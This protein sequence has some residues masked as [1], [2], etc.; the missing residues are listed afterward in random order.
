MPERLETHGFV[1][2]VDEE[3]RRVTVVVSTGDVA[4]DDAVI[5]QRDRTGLA[6]AVDDEASAVRQCG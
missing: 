2:A 4:R 3:R 6:G 1:R 5:D